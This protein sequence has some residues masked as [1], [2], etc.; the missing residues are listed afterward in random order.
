MSTIGGWTIIAETM[1]DRNGELTDDPEQAVNIELVLS[2]G[3][4]TERVWLQANELV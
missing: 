2:K 4:E 3:S 1:V